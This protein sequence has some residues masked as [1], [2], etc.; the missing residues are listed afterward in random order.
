M[1]VCVSERRERVRD[2][3]KFDS[4]GFPGDSVPMQEMWV[5]SLGWVDSVE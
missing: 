3:L 4:V 1:I 2:S 5:P